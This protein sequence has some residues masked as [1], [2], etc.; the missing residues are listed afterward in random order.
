MLYGGRA[1]PHPRFRGGMPS[2]AS[3]YKGEVTTQ[4][5]R[6]E[7]AMRYVLPRAESRRYEKIKKG[8]RRPPYKEEELKR[9]PAGRVA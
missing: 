7:D 3:P 6:E 4:A 9:A 8:S 1:L 2:S 5:P